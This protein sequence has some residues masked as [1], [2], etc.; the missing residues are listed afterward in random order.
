LVGAPARVRTHDQSF[1]RKEWVEK[2]YVGIC[3]DLCFSGRTCLA[4]RKRLTIQARPF[5]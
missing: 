5:L 1:W 2:R 3:G 4:V